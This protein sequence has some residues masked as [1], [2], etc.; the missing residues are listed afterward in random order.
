MAIQWHIFILFWSL[1]EKDI[2]YTMQQSFISNFLIS[3]K[4]EVQLLLKKNSV[5]KN[6][7]I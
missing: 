3:Q 1:V 2:R 6:V 4:Q 5:Y 7:K